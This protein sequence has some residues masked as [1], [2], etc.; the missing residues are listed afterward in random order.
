VRVNVSV[1]ESISMCVCVCMCVCV[2]LFRVTTVCVLRI[3]SY[4][5][6]RLTVQKHIIEH[7]I[8]ALHD[9]SEL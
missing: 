9:L 7:I 2:Q 8:L 4:K 6:Q 3:P 1:C 5:I